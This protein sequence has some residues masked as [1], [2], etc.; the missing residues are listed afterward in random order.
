[1]E[2][3]ELP[4]ACREAMR[5]PK[6][7]RVVDWARENVRLVDSPV[8][9]RYDPEASRYTAAPLEDLRDPEVYEIC[10]VGATGM[11]KTAMF[12]VASCYVTAEQPGPA[13]MIG[14]TNL[15]VKDW[16]ESRMLPIFRRCEATRRLLPTGSKRTNLKKTGI[17][18]R[19]MPYFT[20]G[21]NET[22]TQEKSM[23]YCFG[24][25]PWQWKP[26]IIGHLLR[27]HHDRWNR[28]SLLAAQGGTKGSEWHEHARHGR[29]MRRHFQC[30][31][32]GER[33]E[34]K[35]EQM[36]W[37]VVQDEG[38]EFDW[39]AIG[40]SVRMVC[41]CGAEFEDTPRNRRMLADSGEW[42]AELGPH[43]PGRVTY[44]V[45]FFWVWRIEW[46]QV[47]KEWILAQEAKRSG[48]LEPL[49]QIITKRFAD[50]WEE[51][52]EVPELRTGADPYRKAEFHEGQKWEGED[53]RFLTVDV[54]K[55]HFWG[56]VRA[57]KMGG[58]SRL[59]WEG[60]LETWE[61]V[62]YLRQRMGVAMRFV[63]ID[64][65]YLPDEI[66][67]QRA[68]HRVERGK[69]E[70]GQPIYEYAN[71]LMGEDSD[72]YPVKLRKKRYFR[73]F[74]N[75]IR[76]TTQEGVP[77]QYSKFSN[78]R[79]KDALAGMMRGETF[80]VPT[81]HSKSYAK[82]MVNEAKREV[83]P[84]KWRWVPVTARANNHLWD[85]E[86]MQVVAASICKVLRGMVDAED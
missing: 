43:V 65:G 26:G 31:E 30:P 74:S 12:E 40:E 15:M 9:E 22:T 67:K 37:E 64:C 44:S 84:G 72:G 38:G 55:D 77:Y 28:K 52:S 4:A 11:G 7:Q 70:A 79:A 56:V 16:M 36:Q 61:S 25:E 14:Q 59:V 13:L 60:K 8:G 53:Y 18:F 51:P 86:V 32:C 42:L 35:W 21:A 57:W 69:T 68:T 75:W 39:P 49:K 63:F 76:R 50:F 17:I 5:P 80:G 73:T 1:M 34:W 29:Q 48:D 2:I 83:A 54:Q 20:G 81:D 66:A 10:V 24:D 58:E 46:R 62:W 3:E 23:R 33:H 78:L 47:V 19:H 85:C 6:R 45:P 82:Q 71:M 41:P 27:R